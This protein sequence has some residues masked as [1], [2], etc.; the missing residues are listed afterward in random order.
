MKKHLL[1]GAAAALVLSFSSCDDEQIINLAQQGILGSAEV[2]ITGSNGA[3]AN[4][5]TIEFSSTVMDA[6][7]TVISS[8][9]TVY[10]GTLDLCANIDLQNSELTFPFMGFQVS[11]TLAKTYNMSHV[12][13]R[14]RLRNF[15]FDSIAEI[16][17][18]P[19][20]FNVLLIAI[21]T[22]T[23]FISDAGSITVEKYPNYGGK[24]K[25]R[26]NNIN[27]FYFTKDDAESL[28]EHLD[29]D[30]LNLSD[31]FHPVVISGEF[32]SKRAKFIHRII[33]EFNIRRAQ[34]EQE[35]EEE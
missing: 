29:D 16:V 11:D 5:T 6:F 12:L 14:E 3:F 28:E 24:L 21:D 32:N 25:G 7:D 34:W 4:D 30:N 27:A 17:L 22:N 13:T 35:Q 15:K 20:G 9:D 2:T 19:S 33:E 1:W 8:F 23:W 18:N 10:C 26:F 31:Y